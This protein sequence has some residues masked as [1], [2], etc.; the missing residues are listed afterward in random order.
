MK[1]YIKIIL[2][3]ENGKLLAVRTTQSWEI[4]EMNLDSLKRRYEKGGGPCDDAWWNKEKKEF[5]Y[6]LVE[7]S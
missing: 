7:R 5:T 6:E 3:D 4:A 2:E 1:T